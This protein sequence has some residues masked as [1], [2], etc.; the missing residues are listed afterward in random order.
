MFPALVS[1]VSRKVL[2]L[3]LPDTLSAPWPG[4]EMVRALLSVI[5]PEK[6]AVPVALVAPRVIRPV[7]PLRTATGRPT[8]NAPLITSDAFELPLVLPRFTALEA[9]PRLPAE[10]DG[11]SAPTSN[12][13]AL[14]VV[15]PV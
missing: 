9:L 12:S 4:W 14:I 10:P 1:T 8:L 11:A 15:A 5:V 13:P 2:L 7:L 6:V 3:T